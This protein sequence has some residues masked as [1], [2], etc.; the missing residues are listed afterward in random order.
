[1]AV[2]GKTV[3]WSLLFLLA[4]AQMPPP[5]SPEPSIVYPFRST[6]AVE[7]STVTL[8][9]TF[10]P[11]TSVRIKRKDEKLKIVRVLW[12]QNH[13]IC[14]RET[15]SVYDSNS[16]NNDPRYQYLGDKKR[17]CTLQIRDIQKEDDATFRFRMEADNGAGHFTNRTGVRVF[18]VDGIQMMI[19][20]SSNNNTFT[21]G[22]SVSLQ[23]TTRCTFHQL[24]VT[25]FKD[26]H[27]LSQS[28]PTLHLTS[29][30]AKD[31]GNYTCALKKNMKT[32][33]LQR[34]LQVEPGE[35]EEPGE[36]SRGQTLAVVFGVLLTVIT[37][38]LFV[39]I[40]KRKWAAAA[41]QRT[42]GGEMKHKAPDNIVSGVQ[43]E[44]HEYETGGAVED[45]N[46]ASVQF[47]Y[48]EQGRKGGSAVDQRQCPDYIYS[49]VQT[50][51][52][53]KE[54]SDVSYA[55]VE[56]KNKKKRGRREEEGDAVVYAGVVT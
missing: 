10:T 36:G 2:W 41:G 42:L 37:V 7:G 15:P 48:R 43:T 47:T 51:N 22:E 24:E 46:Y 30:T 9:C 19:Q 25:W 20:S 16:T 5:V 21:R 14:Q 39:F 35:P 52:E 4:D 55:S 26:G 56:F 28:G 40:V 45:V 13:P 12:C 23:C 11:A 27:A 17:N 44:D 49:S 8:P 33:S 29:M 31:S 53:Q 1:M 18:V 50:G 34:S 32:Q 54:S 6:C 3:F 38:G